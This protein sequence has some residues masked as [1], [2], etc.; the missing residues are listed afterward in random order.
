MIESVTTLLDLLGL[1]LLLAGVYLAAGL[2]VSLM[3]AGGLFLI[4]SWRMNGGRISV[5]GWKS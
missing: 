1:A 3:A 2:A 5:G 4:V